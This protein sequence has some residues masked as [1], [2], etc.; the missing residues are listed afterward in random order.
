MDAAAETIAAMG[1]TV[2]NASPISALV[3]YP[4]MSLLEALDAD[5]AIDTRRARCSA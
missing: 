5:P 3:N 4:K 2:I 1:I